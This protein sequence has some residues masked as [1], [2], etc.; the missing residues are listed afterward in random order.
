VILRFILALMFHQIIKFLNQPYP[1]K[2]DFNSQIIGSLVSGVIVFTVLALISPFGME[3]LGSERLFQCAIFGLISA[4]TSMFVELFFKYFVGLKRDVPEWTFW[5]WILSI[6]FLLM[7][8]AIANH[9]Y[10]AYRFGAIQG[11]FS[12]MLYST[13]VVGIV[14]VTIFGSITLI[15]NLKANQ[16]IADEVNVEAA[17]HL[18]DDTLKNQLENDASANV[19]LPIKNSAKTFDVNPSKILFLESMQNYVLIHYLD[20]NDQ[21][22]KETHRNTISSLAEALK[23][24]GIKRTHRSY[25]VN[26]KMIETVSGNA[27][28]L[29][30]DIRGTEFIVPVSRK[31]IPEFKK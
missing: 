13:F 27:Q 30:L 8:I 23:P 14:P 25:L 18:S 5:K 19:S 1:D 4:A 29:K 3:G 20:E 12:R 2:D 15:K 9:I 22:M 11:S 17:T 28:G 7:M 10:G 31:Y 16:K 24:H 6:L 26:P 21:V